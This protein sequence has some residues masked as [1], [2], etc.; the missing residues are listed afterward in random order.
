MSTYCLLAMSV[1]LDGCVETVPV[2]RAADVAVI[3]PK[4]CCTTVPEASCQTAFS[5]GYVTNTSTA[6][7]KL[8]SEPELEEDKTV[9]RDNVVP[10]DV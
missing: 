8:T 7:V 5:D 2:V 3:A 9:V 4:D 10:E 1:L 6:P